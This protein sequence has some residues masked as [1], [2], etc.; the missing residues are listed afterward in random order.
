MKNFNSLLELAEEYNTDLKCRAYL[1]SK[2]WN[3]VPVCAHCGNEDVYRFMNGKLIKCKTCKKQFT[4]TV[5]TIFE[6]SHIPLQKWF[7]GMYLLTA[8]SKGISSFIN[9][10]GLT[11]LLKSPL[12]T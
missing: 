10:E 1:E 3:G 4:V 2:I 6:G 11:V 5:G 8:H 9:I 7:M 12:G